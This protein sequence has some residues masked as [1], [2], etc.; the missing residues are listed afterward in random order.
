MKKN[1]EGHKDHSSSNGGG[2]FDMV[3]GPFFPYRA[4]NLSILSMSSL[5]LTACC[6]LS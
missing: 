3:D 6:R 5:D 4:T 2:A 1:G